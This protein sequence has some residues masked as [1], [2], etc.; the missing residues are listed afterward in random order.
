MK[1]LFNSTSKVVWLICAAISFSSLSAFAQEAPK[2]LNVL[3]TI[4]PIYSLTKNVVGDAANV[5]QLLPPGGEP[6]GFALSPKDLKRLS[7]ADVLVEN[8]GGIEDWLDK[9]VRNVKGLH[10]VSGK[11]VVEGDP[12]PHYW[13]SPL[14]AIKQ[15]EN[16]RKG[17]VE[18]DPANAETY[19][20][21]AAAFTEKLR[22]LDAEIRETTDKMKNKNLLPFHDAFHYFAKDYGFTVVAVFEEFPGRQPGPKYLKRLQNVIKEKGV[23]VLFTEP[24]KS[25]QILRSL[26]EE[27]KLPIVTLDPMEHSKPSAE[28]YELTMRAN[29]KQL[30][31]ALGE[32]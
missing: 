16:I 14:L 8:G 20:K 13:L 31:E 28:L 10:V 7:E 9:A 21:N 23:S 22:A 5:E 19:T 32:Q 29:L 6:H 30:T 2:K 17:L 12:N 15:V 25:P 26:S 3:A 11:G 24:G 4:P 1:T 27:L 18:K